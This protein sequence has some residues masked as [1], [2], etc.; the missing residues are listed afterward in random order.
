MNELKQ[1]LIDRARA[2]HGNIAAPAARRSLD[3]SFTVMQGLL[4]F[5]FNTDN[6]ST[7]VLTEPVPEASRE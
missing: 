1:R 4:V 2:L 5:W 7:H 6:G 3:E